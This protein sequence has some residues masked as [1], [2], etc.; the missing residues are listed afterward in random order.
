[1]ETQGARGIKTGRE[2]VSIVDERPVPG[3]Q[4][5]TKALIDLRDSAAKNWQHNAKHVFS[6]L[7]LAIIACFCIYLLATSDDEKK[8]VFAMTVLS[9]I[10]GGAITYLFQERTRSRN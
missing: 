6:F 7:V 4:K 10:S 1:M 9:S 8:M 5:I 2:E 3:A